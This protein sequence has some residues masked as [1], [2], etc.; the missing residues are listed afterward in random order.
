MFI[1]FEGID[2]AGKST[3][4]G[5]LAQAFRDSGRRVT[6][7][8]EPGGTA[9]AE[10]LR[11][12]ILK[13]PMDA[14]TEALLIFAA[15]RDHLQGVI[16]PAL[17]RGEVVLSVSETGLEP[18]PVHV[19][20]RGSPHAP[21]ERVEPAVPA[22]LATF[23]PPAPAV[24]HGES[25]GR[26]TALA[27]WI[28][29][30]RNR[31]ASRVA[32]NRLWQHH[33]GVGIVPSSNDFGRLGDKP[34]HPELLDWLARRLMADGWSMKAM[35]RLMMTSATYRMSSVPGEAALENDPGNERLSRFRLRRLSAEELRDS[36]LAANG[37]INLERGGPGVRP[38]LPE[39]VL[40][41]SSRP[42]D[43]WPLTPEPSWTRRSVYMHQ[44]RS[45]QDPLLAVFD[46]ADIDN[47]CPVR[48]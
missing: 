9:L 29:D 28:T 21:A 2:G 23:E 10:Q 14:L 31:L 41:T 42:H 4:L 24:A 6:Q 22:V 19:L 8:R 35:H 44:K 33:F 38:P 25:T 3:H 46:Q 45:I 36:L 34:T 26:R 16:Q 48:F 17:A 18:A 27:A 40:A 7:T 30:P 13:Q 20:T 43:V 12:L 39:E 1:S 15:R 11:E 37:T 5:R 47:P 32:V